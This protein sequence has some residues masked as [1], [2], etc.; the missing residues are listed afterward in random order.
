VE[1][2]VGVIVSAGRRVSVGSNE[3]V[4]VGTDAAVGIAGS[5][6]QVAGN[7][8]G[9]GVFIWPIFA[10]TAGDWMIRKAMT[11]LATKLS[12]IRMIMTACGRVIQRLIEPPT[13]DRMESNPRF[14]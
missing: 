11:R 3:A 13:W 8:E 12:S 14:G 9:V 2:P 10:S 7:C 6:V 1:E 4:R 5:D